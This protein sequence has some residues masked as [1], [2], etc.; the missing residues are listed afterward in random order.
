LYT[1]G[2]T[3]RRGEWLAVSLPHVVVLLGVLS[4][5]SASILFKFAS[6]APLTVAFYRLA[7]SVVILAVPLVRRR[8]TWGKGRDL[9]LNILSGLF[10]ALHFA[11][12]FFSL[13]LTSVA[14]STALVSTHPL[15]VLLVGYVAWG[16]R[17]R[18][19]AVVGVGM[20]VL[21]AVLVGWGDF[22]MDTRALQGDLLAFAGAITVSGYFLIG[23]HVRQ[24]VDALA[25]SVTAYSSASLALL[26]MAVLWGSPLTGFDPGNWGIFAALAIFPTIFGHTLFNWALKHL[27]ASVISVNILGE[28]VGATLLAWA[29]WRA[30]PGPTALVGGVCILSGIGLFLWTQRTTSNQ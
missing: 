20:S 22:R 12:W 24:R 26:V 3:C 28:P 11:T 10:L 25:Y 21:G 30:L 1:R 19:L 29:I 14:S 4:V 2:T 6:A 9:W 17:P 8:V 13:Q 18:G 23:R 27:P 15:I 16:E 5:S 7:L